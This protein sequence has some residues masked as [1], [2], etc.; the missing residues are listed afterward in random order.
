[1]WREISATRFASLKKTSNL[2]FFTFRPGM[3][4]SLSG[5]CTNAARLSGRTSSVS[6]RSDL[7]PETFKTLTL[8]L[9]HLDPETLTLIFSW[10]CLV[11]PSAAGQS[12]ELLQ[13]GEGE[14]PRDEDGLRWHRPQ[15]AQIHPKGSGIKLKAE[16]GQPSTID[17]SLD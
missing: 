3:T 7:D 9:W 11:N 8:R 5:R 4:W 13:G 12:Q 1:M 14:A 17:G 10:G 2:T 16:I 15:S 6:S